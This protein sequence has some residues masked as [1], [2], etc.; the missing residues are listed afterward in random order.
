MQLDIRFL[1]KILNTIQ[2]KQSHY[3]LT[4]EIKEDVRELYEYLN[5]KDYTDLFAGHMRLLQD[6]NIIEEVTGNNTLGIQYN[7]N[8]INIKPCKIRL[9][10]KGHDFIKVLNKNGIVDKL[11]NFTVTECLHFVNCAIE[12]SIKNLII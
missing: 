1:R 6:N 10:S 3:V 12:E 9:T 4:T 2:E 8:G 7:V 11:K 5:S